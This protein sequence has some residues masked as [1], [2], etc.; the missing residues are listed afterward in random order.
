MRT[1]LP[2]R[3][4]GRCPHA[5][6]RRIV[7]SETRSREATSPTVRNSLPLSESAPEAEPRADVV[8]QLAQ[9]GIAVLA[10]LG[11]C[12]I[13]PWSCVPPYGDIPKGTLFRGRFW[14]AF[15]GPCR[16]EAHAAEDCS[17][18]SGMVARDQA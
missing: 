2:T 14:S 12:F 1:D 4:A 11:L 17:Q 7:F 8:L 16:V 18:R 5:I 6:K 9:G 10:D 3:Q 15:S 13:H